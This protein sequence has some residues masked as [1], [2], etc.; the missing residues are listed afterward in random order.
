MCE[1]QGWGNRFWILD[2]F[3]PIWRTP[4]YAQRVPRSAFLGVFVSLA[5]S[6][7]VST[8]VVAWHL[9]CGSGNVLRNDVVDLLPGWGVGD[10]AGAWE[11]FVHVTGAVDD[12][13]VVCGCGLKDCSVCD[14]EG[15]IRA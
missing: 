5:V 11:Y 3:R 12:G 7:L 15:V 6:A 1:I 14:N 8:S 9:S 4:C 10:C 13:E 2:G